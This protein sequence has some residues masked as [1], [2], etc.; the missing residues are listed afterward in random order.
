MFFSINELREFLSVPINLYWQAWKRILRHLQ[1]IASYGLQLF[2]SGSLPLIAYSHEKCKLD[3]NDKR[4]MGGY[5]IFL[6]ENHP[7]DKI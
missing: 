1:Y 7:R 3:S 5:S 6:G 4:S 2:R